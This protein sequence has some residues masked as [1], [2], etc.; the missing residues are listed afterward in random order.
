MQLFQK[1]KAFSESFS[2]FLKSN[3]SFEHFQKEDHPHT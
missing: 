3:L 2:E 1:Q